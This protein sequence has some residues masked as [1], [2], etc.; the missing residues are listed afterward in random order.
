METAKG[1]YMMTHS[2]N[3]TNDN[4]LALQRLDNNLECM[5]RK[6]KLFNRLLIPSNSNNN[7]NNQQYAQSIRSIFLGISEAGMKSSDLR[8][9]L[10]SMTIWSFVL[11]DDNLLQLI[12]YDIN[13]PKYAQNEKFT[14][15]V[16]GIMQYVLNHFRVKF[17]DL[18]SFETE[19]E[20]Q[21]SRNVLRSKISRLLQQCFVLCPF[22]GLECIGQYTQNILDA[23]AKNN[24]T[25]NINSMGHCTINNQQYIAMDGLCNVYRIIFENSI[26]YKFNKT[27]AMKRKKMSQHIKLL[28][29]S[30]FDNNSPLIQMLEKI[31]DMII[32]WKCNNN[33]TQLMSRI[34]PLLSSLIPLYCRK[35]KYLQLTFERLL[36]DFPKLLPINPS[37]K[38]G[39]D[40]K[41]NAVSCKRRIAFSLLHI[42]K[43][44]PHICVQYIDPIWKQVMNIIKSNFTTFAQN[45]TNHNK[46][47]TNNAI[48][49]KSTH[50]KPDISNSNGVIM[51]T[52]ME[53]SEGPVC[54]L[55]EL[56]VCVSNGLKDT[57]ARSKKLSELLRDVV[58][59]FNSPDIQ[60]ILNDNKQFAQMI[61]FP[62]SSNNNNSNDQQSVHNVDPR[63][64]FAYHVR[65]ILNILQS[66][67]TASLLS[68]GQTGLKDLFHTANLDGMPNV[69]DNTNGSLQTIFNSVNNRPKDIP[70]WP[71]F[72]EVFP[73]VLKLNKLLSFMFT[74]QFKKLLNP[75]YYAITRALDVKSLYN[76]F[77]LKHD[78]LVR[79][80]TA[81]PKEM[82]PLEKG[83]IWIQN[84]RDYISR[85][86]CV[87]SYFD[88]QFFGNDQ[89]MDMLTESMIAYPDTLPLSHLA[90]IIKHFF[91]NFVQLCSPKYYPNILKF[92]YQFLST[93]FN[94]LDYCWQHYITEYMQ[95]NKINDNNNN[96]GKNVSNINFSKNKLMRQNSSFLRD[97]V[98]QE[99]ALRDSSQKLW[100]SLAM[101]TI[102]HKERGFILLHD[103][104]MNKKFRKK[105]Q[106]LIPSKNINNFNDEYNN[107]FLKNLDSK[108]MDKYQIDNDKKEDDNNDHNKNKNKE[109]INLKQD[110][111]VMLILQ[112]EALCKCII[113][114]I[115]RSLNWLDNSCHIRISQVASKFVA[116]IA[117]YRM[118]HLYGECGNILEAA[119]NALTRNKLGDNQANA[120]LNILCVAICQLLGPLNAD[121]VINVLKTVPNVAMEDAKGLD[122]LIRSQPGK[123]PAATYRI[124]IKSFTTKYVIGKQNV[125]SSS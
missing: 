117:K 35:P 8:I 123:H 37:A 90:V 118:K 50:H 62:V 93:Y 121:I 120:E 91:M 113:S 59:N 73:N 13:K 41:C 63:I 48:P 99:F 65:T 57:N 115:I 97:E 20:W 71:F 77:S 112:N 58:N 101:I 69:L 95:N 94:K 53:L 70:S 86:I 27:K 44:I 36:N 29:E 79:N 15:I 124:S 54:H 21:N 47:N 46:N 51:A 33:D 56:L 49:I 45:G 105:K 3:K 81:K 1:L 80:P 10:R 88:D 23:N 32:K 106:K 72:I 114:G 26:N 89:A 12:G 60:N 2:N 92:L 52:V 98:Y 5:T 75:N 31:H 7:S 6:L 102:S 14:N 30:I 109:E 84:I 103:N 9:R 67:L 40:I 24:D 61:Q 64:R 4:N 119:L 22:R 11:D 34:Y 83:V 85:I 16:I 28:D 108:F 96:N 68:E 110:K 74:D 82:I 116:F 78:E 100:M 104:K 76:L 43:R 107:D 122:K 19:E 66:T 39:F 42:A 55:F 17:H 111:L 25:I 18:K 87:A 38:D 125:L